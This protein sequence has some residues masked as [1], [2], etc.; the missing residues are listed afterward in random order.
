[1]NS[2]SWLIAWNLGLCFR[3]G[4][5]HQVDVEARPTLERQ[6]EQQ[7]TGINVNPMHLN[8]LQHDRNIDPDNE[9]DE[10]VIPPTPK[11]SSPLRVRECGSTSKLNA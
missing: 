1:M 10:V 6:V 8:T 7:L 5:T 3:N 2:V 4:T 11:L 9:N